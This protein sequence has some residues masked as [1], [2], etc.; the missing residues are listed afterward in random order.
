M[1]TT[2]KWTR[3]R[4][5]IRKEW[6]LQ[7]WSVI[8]II[9]TI[10]VIT[11]V[12]ISPVIAGLYN[13]TIVERVFSGNTWFI[14]HMYMGV[15]L[16]FISLANEL[17]RPDIWLHSTASARQLIGAKIV[18]SSLAV[19]ISLVL[20]GTLMSISA[21]KLGMS[22]TEILLF[23]G[24]IAVFVLNALYLMVVA[25]FIW[26]IYNVLRARIGKFSILVTFLFV[27][28]S[29]IAWAV[30]WTTDGIQKTIEFWP[31]LT[32]D[33]ATSAYPYLHETNFILS[34]LMPEKALIT[35]GSLF[36]YV[37]ISLGVFIAGASLFEKKVRL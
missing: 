20:S 14:L 28:I 32:L 23:M 6:A 25:F 17:K 34:G 12:E 29:N 18:F 2:L 26:S 33:V 4:G 31:L 19:T 30:I 27:L 3:W 35:V 36:L 24:M 9:A 11:I 22:W 8:G 7:K 21:F 13:E 37:V 16:L 10:L 15:F 5:L 1:N